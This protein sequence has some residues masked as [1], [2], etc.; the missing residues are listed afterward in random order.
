MKVLVT[1]IGGQLGH[2]V[3]KHLDAL[4]IDHIGADRAEFDITD[5]A[6]TEAFILGYMPDVVV[7]CSAY[8]AVDKA[9]EEKQKCFEVNTV[10]TEN[11]AKVCKKIDAKMMY[12]STDYVFPGQGDQFYEVDDVTDPLSQYG[13]TKLAGELAVKRYLEKYFIVRISLVFG[14]NGHNFI[15]TMLRL[16]KTH[17]EVRVVDDQIGSPTYTD[18]LSVLICDMIQTEKYGTYHATNEGIC[19]WADFT[20][21]IFRQA[22]IASCHVKHVTTEEYGLSAAV[23][24]F[25]SRLSKKSLDEAGFHRLPA[26]QDALHRYLIELGEIEETK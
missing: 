10:G 3:M 21:E 16:G 7:H 23:R 1:G 26:W 13:A 9:E 24:P 18:D 2:D 8:T 14:V 17:D 20:E 12:F 15:K 11:I 25:N 22:G 19:S 6:A 5:Q 4:G